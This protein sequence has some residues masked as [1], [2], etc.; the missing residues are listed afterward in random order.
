MPTIDNV[1]EVFPGATVDGT[2]LVIPLAAIPTFDGVMT[3]GSNGGAECAL[4]VLDC[5]ANSVVPL[6]SGG[7]TQVTTNNFLQ[8][9]TANSGLLSRTYT[10]TASIGLSLDTAQLD[11]IPPADPVV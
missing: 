9:L 8:N 3:G 4:G 1:N 2:N 6:G 5:L 10:F 7:F 11:L